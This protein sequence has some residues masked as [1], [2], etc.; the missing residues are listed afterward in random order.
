M[1]DEDEEQ[2]RRN[3]EDR[4]NCALIK[5]SALWAWV[6]GLVQRRICTGHKETFA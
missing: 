1:S 2:R 4:M 6:W 3:N 5:G